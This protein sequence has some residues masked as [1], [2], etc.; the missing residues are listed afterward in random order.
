MKEE[1]ND[2]IN[3]DRK[4][5]RIRTFPEEAVTDRKTIE[6]AI[7]PKEKPAPDPAE[8]ELSPEELKK[9]RKKRQEELL[10]KRLANLGEDYAKIVEVPL[11]GLKISIRKK[12]KERLISAEATNYDRLML[13]QSSNGYWTMYGHSALIYYDR[14]ADLLD[15]DAKIYSDRDSYAKSKDGVVSIR[16]IRKLALDLAGAG[17]KLNYYGEGFCFFKLKNP[18]TKS[19]ISEIRSSRK[20][21]A[22]ELN[23]NIYPKNPNVEA[24][25]TLREINKLSYNL[26]NSLKS[27]LRDFALSNLFEHVRKL[28]LF[29]YQYANDQITE[30]IWKMNSDDEIDVMLTDIGMIADVEKISIKTLV[31]ISSALAKYRIILAAEVA[32]FECEL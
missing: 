24:K 27:T 5:K 16:G 25:K 7:K 8:K 9:L 17:I 10:Q 15:R 26:S 11:T 31:L 29:Y 23:H 1:E 21:L 13:I 28:N 18:F 14:I 2:P 22:E 32:K 3:K 6:E 30:T 19:M 4:L 12:M 20:A